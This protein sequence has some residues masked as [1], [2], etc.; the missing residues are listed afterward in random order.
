MSLS[1]T[2]SHTH[3]QDEKEERRKRAM[4]A[5][6]RIMQRLQKQQSEFVEKHKEELASTSTFELR[7]DTDVQMVT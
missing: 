6:K 5:R 7:E 3:T 1:L 4:E 2:L